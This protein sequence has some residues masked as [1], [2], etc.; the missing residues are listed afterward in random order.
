MVHGEAV[1]NVQGG[2]LTNILFSATFVSPGD[3]QVL[4]LENVH[5][6]HHHGFVKHLH[7]GQSL[8]L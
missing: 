7:W 5:L 2:V 8:C 4:R 6:L 1:S 3:K